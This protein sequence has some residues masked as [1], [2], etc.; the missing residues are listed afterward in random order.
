[1]SSLRFLTVN[2]KA[3]AFVIGSICKDAGIPP[4][5]YLGILDSY[6]AFDI[7][8]GITLLMAKA[9]NEAI[10]NMRKQEAYEAEERERH[11]EPLIIPG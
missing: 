1:M 10:E 5:D 11:R 6:V 4:S 9:E 2:D 3:N 7:D 8:R